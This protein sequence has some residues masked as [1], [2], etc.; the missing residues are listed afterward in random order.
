[1]NDR[2][3]TDPGLPTL[4]VATSGGHLEQLRN[5]YPRFLPESAS[6]EWVSHTSEQLEALKMAGHVVHEVPY[7]GP[8][9]YRALTQNIQPALR[10]LR[11]NRYARIISTGAGIAIPYALAGKLFR[12]PYHYIESQ[13][14][15]NG[16]SFTGNLLSRLPNI[17]LYAQNE[18]WANS[19]WRYRGS[20]ID[21]YTAERVSPPRHVSRVVVTLGTMRRYGFRRAIERL[22]RVL[23]TVV[24]PNAEILWQ[25]GC[26]DV[27]GLNIKAYPK[28]PANDLQD[29]IGAADLVAMHAGVGSAL[30]ALKHGKAPILM[31]RQ[32]DFGEHIDDH[33][34]L[35]ANELSERGLAIAT[36]PDALTREHIIDALSTKVLREVRPPKFEL[37][38]TQGTS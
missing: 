7:I 1:M 27:T 20:G 13:T 22:L 3:I 14:R 35:L 18:S 36:S 11:A 31:P 17:N 23:P 5:L 37:A 6:V 33:Q 16:P 19:K 34:A 8:R 21:G 25:T 32:S 2:Q 10:L 29:A 26:T 12:T 30:V 38:T 15:L 24:D 4:L 28:V 9:G